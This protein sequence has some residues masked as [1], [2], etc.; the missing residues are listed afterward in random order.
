[1]VDFVIPAEAINSPLIQVDRDLNI[2]NINRQAQIIFAKKREELIGE[3]YIA[4]CQAAKIRLPKNL[5]NAIQN[6]SICEFETELIEND[7]IKTIAWNIIT[8]NTD[9]VHNYIFLGTDISDYKKLL[10]KEEGLQAYLE[11]ILD[12]IP[13]YIYWKDINS[14]YMGCNKKFAQAAGLASPE[15][16]IGKTDYD[17]AWGKTEAALFRQGDLEVLR[18][19]PKLDF[20]EP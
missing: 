2:L 16:V 10:Q 17:F 11:H 5:V 15:E 14:V 12:N 8:L 6:K 7:Y 19:I 13:C 1:M 3:N 9:Q 20:E 18:G 4:L